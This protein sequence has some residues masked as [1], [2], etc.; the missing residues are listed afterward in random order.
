MSKA[1]DKVNHYG[2]LIKLMNRNVPEVSLRVLVNWYDKCTGCVRWNDALSRC[3]Y[4][5][6]G[7]RQGGVLSPL[8]FALYVN[9]MLQK[10]CHK[11]LDCYV[12][13]V[14]C[15]CI[16]YADDLVL[17]SPSV[18]LLQKMIDICCEEAMYLD[19]KF[20]ALKSNIIGPRCT[21]L[22]AFHTIQPS[23]YLCGLFDIL[24]FPFISSL[25]EMVNK[26]C[27]YLDNRV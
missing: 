4:L 23:S 16:M 12:G 14:F 15:G 8:L 9:D 3:F 5:Y 24:F 18:S 19:M 1:F 20:N 7:V 13:D 25:P 22:W 17:V 2:M 6:C 21:V 26:S 10:L 27:I 11:R